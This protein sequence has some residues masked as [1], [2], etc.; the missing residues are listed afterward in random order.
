MPDEPQP[1][2]GGAADRKLR[3]AARRVGHRRAEPL[4]RL[5]PGQRPPSPCC[6]PASPGS[7]TGGIGS[8][9]FSARSSSGGSG[10][11]VQAV[12]ASPGRRHARGRGAAHRDARHARPAA[13]DR[14]AGHGRGRARRRRARLVAREGRAAAARDDGRDRRRD[15]GRRP[16][17]PGGARRRRHRDRQARH[18][19]QRDAR[20]DRGGVRR[21]PRLG[22]AAAAVRRRRLARAADADHVDPRGTRSCSAAAPTRGPTTSPGRW[23]GSR[24]EAERMG[25]LVDDLLL[26]ARLDQGRP[27]EREPVDLAPVVADAVDA[28]RAIDPDR[29]L[30][31]DLNGSAIVTGD[32]GRLR[33]VVDNLLENA[34]VHTPPATPTH[35]ALGPRRRRGRPDGR[36]RGSGDG[37]R[38]RGQ[39]VRALLPR[40]SGACT[41]DRRRRA[42]ACRSSPRSWSPRWHRPRARDDGGHHDRGAGPRRGRDAAGPASAP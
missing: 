26:L 31:A 34:R 23:R 40:R 16:V 2:S 36:R 8:V 21:T 29:V 1:A 12:R 15:R 17:A 37:C 7:T 6:P 5:P 24:R 38:G 33:Q 25:V 41:R 35:V 18:L 11:R 4:V 20:P 9:T 28:A 42:R 3:G 10:F 14:S 30:D 27:L 32:A 22:G 19:A 13:R 39:G